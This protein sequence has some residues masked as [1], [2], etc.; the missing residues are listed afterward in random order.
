MARDN[1]L[2]FFEDI[3]R[4]NDTFIVHDDGYRVRRATYRQVAAAARAF[5]RKLIDAGVEPGDTVVI[6]S[7]NRTEWVVALWG[8]LLV[9]AVLV[10]VD[11]RASADL[12]TRIT[13]IVQAKVVLTGDEV[14]VPT[15]VT[16]HVWTLA[17]VITIDDAEAGGP[18]RP[19]AI[20]AP[21]APWRP[22]GSPDG[23]SLA[24]IIFTSGATSEPKGVT[25]THR[26]VLA[27]I[28]PIEREIGKYRRYVR[29]VHPLRFL[30]LLPLS[31]MFGQSMATFVP[32]M[33]AG[34]VVFSH[35]Y[36]PVEI[37]RQIKTRRVSVLV[38]VPKVLDVLR[39]HVQRLY[40]HTA[41]PDP[42]AGKHWLWR[43]WH[44]R[45]VRRLFGWKFWAMVCGAAPLD[46]EL[47]AF[48]RKL[49]F[50]VVQGYGLTETAP[51]VTLNHPLRSAKG[52]VGRP[53]GGVKVKIA[54]DGE[55]LVQGENV[56]QG[57]YRP[58][59]M[60]DVAAAEAN[61]A[62]RDGWFHTGDIGEI[63]PN[64]RLLIKGRK[65]EMIVTP[66]GLNVFPEDVERALL[67]QPGVREAA[68][69]G[70]KVDGEERI[71][72]VLVLDD[73]ADM[74]AIV[75][76][77]NTGLEDH[78][79]VWSASIWTN[80]PLPRT[81]GTQKLKRKELQRWASGE[82][83]TSRAASGGTSLADI[84][85][86]HVAG[87][88]LE[89]ETTLEELGLS[90]LDR[91][92]LM[93]EL[94][95]AFHTT[96]DESMLTGDR[97]LRDLEALLAGSG[98]GLA[99]PGGAVVVGGGGAGA[100]GA[101]RSAAADTTIR[102]PSWN[103][104]RP[105]WFLR[106][107]SLPTWI[108]PLG[109]PFM[110]LKVE[111]LEHLEGLKGPVLFAANHQSHMDTPAIMLALPPARRYGLAVA[112]AKEFFAAHFYPAGRPLKQRLKGTTLYLLSC[113]FF[114][115]FPLPQR[116]AGARQTLRYV[117]EVAADGYSILIFPEGRRTE[118]GEIDR[119]QPGVGMIGAKL[120]L[121]VVPVRLDGLE[122]VLGKSMRW[123][124]RGPVRVAFGAPIQLTGEDYPAMA[125]R[126]EEAVRGL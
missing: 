26:N 101:P 25:I 83:T 88:T 38:S 112:M 96:L 81:E 28:I 44:Y 65:K 87:R 104:S 11:F 120:G 49:G 77:A 62:F 53:I 14:D 18:G 97:S 3:S 92:E 9:R 93:M 74:N 19:S 118:T 43:W 7:E 80:G 119:F 57:Y 8:T 29:I 115:A 90:S 42:L 39:D 12:L 67:Q 20:P 60:G 52:T 64:G 75:R 48:W 121:P 13:G 4:T 110:D 2:D 94:E 91:V 108:L 107:I 85:G 24:E 54:D 6:W 123:P 34:T 36:S 33:L 61:A 50:V 114:N 46:P 122:R 126:V 5:G 30:N 1:L 56:T 73:G 27:N 102:F 124:V 37:L 117:G 47:E 70:L 41:E 113:Q 10:P 23:K 106:R 78:Q 105:S 22:A 89:A 21:A 17:D 116:E 125:K 15:T 40:P 59:G 32:P 99:S 71:H 84:I 16:G 35:G 31:H 111:G 55:I 100:P 79:R 68:V 69:V 95:E 72:A 45:D 98:A 63:D 51:I 76:G 82:A 66:Q 86:R 58:E 109:Y 103:R